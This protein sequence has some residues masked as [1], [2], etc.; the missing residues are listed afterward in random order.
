M[1]IVFLSQWVGHRMT[2]YTRSQNFTGVVMIPAPD[3]VRLDPVEE[4]L[5]DGPVFI[6]AAQITAFRVAE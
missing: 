1:N 4:S 3:V 5:S 2:V 6:D